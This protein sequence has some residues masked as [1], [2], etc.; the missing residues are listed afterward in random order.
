LP[1]LCERRPAFFDEMALRRAREQQQVDAGGGQAA[2]QTTGRRQ[3]EFSDRGG[4]S[5]ECLASS[6]DAAKARAILLSYPKA[7]E[8]GY[9]SVQ[10]EGKGP[11]FEC[12]QSN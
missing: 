8:C 12:E 10:L 11:R 6:R 5:E 4:T 7:R 9:S 1:T 2:S 3:V